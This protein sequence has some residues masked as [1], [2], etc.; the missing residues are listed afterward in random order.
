MVLLLPIAMLNAEEMPDWFKIKN[1][2]CKLYFFSRHSHFVWYTVQGKQAKVI[3]IRSITFV[4]APLET[5]YCTVQFGLEVF[6]W[7]LGLFALVLLD[8]FSHAI[9]GIIKF[10]SSYFKVLNFYF[11]E[12]SWWSLLMTI[13]STLLKMLSEKIRFL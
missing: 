6:C 5:S 11:L 1:S 7:Y 13:Q 12:L 10:L 8:S 2:R 4:H 3:N 9:S